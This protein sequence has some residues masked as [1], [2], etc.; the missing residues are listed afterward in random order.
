M[1]KPTPFQFN[2]WYVAAAGKEIAAGAMI[3]R[4]LLGETVLLLRTDAGEAKAMGGICPHR[5]APLVMGKFNGR[6]VACTY[7]GLRLN[8]DG[9]CVHNPRGDGAINARMNVKSYPVV[10]RYGLL[11]IWMGRSSAADPASIPNDFAF[12]DEAPERLLAG[13]YLHTKADYRLV[14]DNLLDASHA[15][16]LHPE[17]L[18]SRGLFCGVPAVDQDA[19]RVGVTFRTDAAPVQALFQPFMTDPDVMASQEHLFQWIRPS[20]M[21]LRSLLTESGAEEPVMLDSIH[22]ITPE[23]EGSCHYWFSS[24]R[25]FADFGPEVSEQIANAALATFIGEDKPVLEAVERAMAGRDF[26]EMEPA[27]LPGDS[28]SVIVR[29][30]IAKAIKDEA[31]DAA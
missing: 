17:L 26:F 18:S 9:E 5:F 12:L 3:E 7:H 20:I 1:S 21:H 2:A 15:D 31:A 22:A 24:T 16:F 23:T 19:D 29:R 14:I 10:E 28:A 4:K 13:G 6:E 11:W 27:L 30:R 25:N 8:V